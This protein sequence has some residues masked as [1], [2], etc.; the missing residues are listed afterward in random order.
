MHAA[1]SPTRTAA[2]AND[3]SAPLPAAA[4]TSSG[5]EAIAPAGAVVATDWAKTPG[6]RRERRRSPATGERD[7]S[8]G[9]RVTAD[10][11]A[12]ARPSP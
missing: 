10:L 5:V 9:M 3:H 11:R 12:S 7:R 1:T 4:M 6:G 2:I 8:T